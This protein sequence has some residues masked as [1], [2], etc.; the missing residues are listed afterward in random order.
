MM[1]VSCV[2]RPGSKGLFQRYRRTHSLHLPDSVTLKMEAVRFSE[3][4]EQTF[5][6][7]C[8]NQ[9]KKRPSFEKLL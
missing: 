2:L 9:K 3:T 1:V 5:T 4:S 6:T 8:E 7:H